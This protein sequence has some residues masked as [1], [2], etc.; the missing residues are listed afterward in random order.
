MIG[1]RL[2]HYVIV[3][4]LVEGG[5]GVVYQAEDTNLGRAVALKF[6]PEEVSRDRAALE[7]FHRE[8]RTASALNHPNI[9]TIYEL[10]EHE[11]R[12]FIAME[13]L[14]GQTLRQRIAGKPMKPEEV[15][16]LGI[17]ITSSSFSRP[18]TGIPGCARP[19]FIRWFANVVTPAALSSCGAPWPAC[20]PRSVSRSCVWKPFPE[21][22]RRSIGRTSAMSWWAAPRGG[23]LQ[24]CWAE[25]RHT[26]SRA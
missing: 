5:M 23:P 26:R 4:K 18:W 15:V 25:E 7:R 24:V 8:A 12:P 3:G 10:G 22:R 11:G 19:A 2:L 9:C 16:E 1:R 14:E 20:A 21:S 13:P 17:Q 6:L